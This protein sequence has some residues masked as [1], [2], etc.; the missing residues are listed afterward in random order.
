MLG[1][2]RTHRASTSCRRR[3]RPRGRPWL[4]DHL[5]AVRKPHAPFVGHHRDHLLRHRVDHRT[6]APRAG[7]EV[8]RLSAASSFLFLPVVSA[9]ASPLQRR[10]GLDSASDA[11]SFITSAPRPRSGINA[12]APRLCTARRDGPLVPRRVA[13]HT[14]RECELREPHSHVERPHQGLG[15]WVLTPSAAETSKDGE[16]LVEERLG[17]MLRSYRRVA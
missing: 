1:P 9:A 3:R 6:A 16:V 4:R 14:M 13:P 15:N 2:S 5:A 8:V 12:T 7:T 10:S 17:G 11:R